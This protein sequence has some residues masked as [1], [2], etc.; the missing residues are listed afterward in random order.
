M[1]GVPRTLGPSQLGLMARSYM[2]MSDSGGLQEGST[3]FGQPMVLMRDTTDRPEAV[4]TGSVY[5]AG[6]KTEPIYDVA[7]RLLHDP[8]FYNKMATGRSLGNSVFSNM[9]ILLSIAPNS[10]A[11]VSLA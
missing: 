1:S 11:R 5:L 4:E 3:V 9:V 8:I 2:V 10:L 6:T 7:S